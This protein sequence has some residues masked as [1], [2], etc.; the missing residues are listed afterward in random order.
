MHDAI[1]ILF[2]GLKVDVSLLA[3]PYRGGGHPED[4]GA[5]AG[6]S[7]TIKVTHNLVIGMGFRAVMDFVEDQKRYLGGI[8]GF[9]SDST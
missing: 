9:S 1:C 6:I 2:K 4:L 5:A 3:V 7:E 8:S